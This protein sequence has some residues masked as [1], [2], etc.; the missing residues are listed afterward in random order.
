MGR[1]SKL[2]EVY[3]EPEVDDIE[4]KTCIYNIDG[5]KVEVYYENNENGESVVKSINTKK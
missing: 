2:T 4:K 1:I 5:E 3:G